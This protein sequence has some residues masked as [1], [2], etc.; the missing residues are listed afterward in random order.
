MN[1]ILSL[2]IALG[3]NILFFVPAFIFKTDKLTDFSYGL[4][5][6][7]I[8]LFGLLNSAKNLVHFIL[9]FMIFFWS[10]R[11][12][13][14]LLI[15]ILKTGKDKRFD[16]IRHNFFK[17]LGFWLLQG[18]SVW[19]IIIPSVLLFNVKALAITPISILGV[20]I[21][22]LGLTVETIADYQKFN[23]IHS[24][25]NKGKWIKA[26]LWKY[27]Q[28]PNY[29]GEI[30]NWL[31]IYIFTISYLSI[32]NIL[33]SFISPIFITILLVFVTGI[34]KADQASFKRW[35]KNPNYIEYKNKTNKLILWPF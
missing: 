2:Q 23:F 14:Y 8:A 24:K 17:F 27:S 29:F 15:R 34:P 11:L 28:H 20:L 7:I 4:T 6:F 13:S 25:E 12:V 22:G 18:I 19:V 3:I 32:G 1:L 30:L 16:Q 5:F 35:G 21:W 31:G 10:L 33:L 26:G 9:F